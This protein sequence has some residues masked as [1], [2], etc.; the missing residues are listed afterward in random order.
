MQKQK[1]YQQLCRA[2]VMNCC[3]RSINLKIEEHGE[4]VKKED[5]SMM[6][7]IHLD[8]CCQKALFSEW[9]TYGAFELIR[10][11]GGHGYAISS[12]MIVPMVDLFPNTILEGE[13]SILFL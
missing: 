5:F 12:G 4:R 9:E 13:N 6:K 8:L 3:V 7:M 1:I 10:A 11:C 2:L